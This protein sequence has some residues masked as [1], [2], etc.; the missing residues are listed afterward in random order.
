MALVNDDVAVFG[1][2]VLYFALPM[3][4]LEQSH[5]DKTGA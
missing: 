1:D 2:E 3:K 5:V 4:A